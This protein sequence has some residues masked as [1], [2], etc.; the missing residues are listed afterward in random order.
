VSWHDLDWLDVQVW[1]YETA[2]ND[3]VRESYLAAHSVLEKTFNA[4]KVWYEETMAKATGEVDAETASQQLMYTEQRWHEQKQ[5]LAAMALSLLAGLNKSFLDQLK[6]L[7]GKTH[8]P[9]PKGYAGKSQIHRQIA[10]YKVRFNVDLEKIKTFGSLREVE[11][12]RHCCLHNEGELT[13]DYRQQT[14]CRLVGQDGKINMTPDLLDL[15][16]LELATFSKEISG[17]LKVL[18]NAR[19]SPPKERANLRH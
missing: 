15:F 6:G 10:E 11:L 5:A 17:E 14:K 3:R 9:E 4:R 13:P 19:T 2:L 7:F 12:A 1:E 8:P 16:I 18:R